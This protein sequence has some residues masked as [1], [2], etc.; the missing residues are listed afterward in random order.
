MVTNDNENVPYFRLVP[1]LITTPTPFIYG[2]D[3]FFLNQFMPKRGGNATKTQVGVKENKK[4][5]NSVLNRKHGINLSSCLKD[6][7]ECEPDKESIRFHL[8]ISYALNDGIIQLSSFLFF[9]LF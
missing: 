5:G 2:I 4:T 6:R 1:Q 3:V 7:E 9:L 8:K